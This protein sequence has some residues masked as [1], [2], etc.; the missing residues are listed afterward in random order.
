MSDTGKTRRRG[1]ASRRIGDSKG[2]SRTLRGPVTRKSNEPGKASSKSPAWEVTAADPTSHQGFKTWSSTYFKVGSGA[3]SEDSVLR[4]IEGLSTSDIP[5]QSVLE[6]VKALPRNAGVPL[7][8]TTSEQVGLTI[9][10][11][12]RHN[13]RSLGRPVKP[14]K[15]D[16]DTTRLLSDLIALKRDEPIRIVV[17]APRGQT[18]PLS[19]ET[20]LKA[21]KRILGL[22]DADLA[23]LFG[24]TRR[25]VE[26]WQ[27]QIPAKRAEKV[28]AVYQVAQLLDEHLRSELIPGIARTPAEVYDGRTMLDLIKNDEHQRLLRLTEQGFT[29][30]GIA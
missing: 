25:S 9:I 24:V 3:L 12:F 5:A 29:Y 2:S 21:I 26:K 6:S 1:L 4:A 19:A 23:S 22:S 16:V 13:L 11:A 7:A 14:V 8:D 18:R 30:E 15:L 17:A 20:I 28:A 27:Q 10:E